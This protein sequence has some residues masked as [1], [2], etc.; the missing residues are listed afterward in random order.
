VHFVRGEYPGVLKLLD[1]SA[2]KL[3]EFHPEQFGV[4]TA[5]LLA[6]VERVRTEFEALGPERFA[7]FDER[8]IP[9]IDVR[10]HDG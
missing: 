7:E 5:A 9:R 4:D 3:R 8:N 6:S 2:E 10:Q 1:A